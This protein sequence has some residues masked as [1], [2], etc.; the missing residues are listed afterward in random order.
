MHLMAYVESAITYNLGST[1]ILLQLTELL[2]VTAKTFYCTT[3]PGC[4]RD[5]GGALNGVLATLTSLVLVVHVIVA[6]VNKVRLRGLVESVG[7]L[8]SSFLV[9]IKVVY[10]YVR[11][12]KLAPT[13]DPLAHLS[14]EKRYYYLLQIYLLLTCL[15]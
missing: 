13:F 14:R 11:L 8:N 6:V 2:Q 1:K 5:E 3:V 12:C 10:L 9:G 15:L 7:S 4:K